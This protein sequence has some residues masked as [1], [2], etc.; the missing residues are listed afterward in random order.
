MSDLHKSL[1]KDMKQEAPDEFH[2]RQR[3]DFFFSAISII[4]PFECDLSIFDIQDTVVGNCYTVSVP[5]KVVND[6]GRILER[7]LTVCDPL[8]VVAL[9]YQ[10]EKN[11]GI[12]IL[13]CAAAEIKFHGFQ[14]GKE[15]A[16][17]HTGK[18]LHGNEKLLPG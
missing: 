15:L 1:G 18:H 9:I 17:K 3:H 12:L 2:G 7:R 10:I 13:L 8:L 5:P 14:C 11:T 6:S 16:T 4:P